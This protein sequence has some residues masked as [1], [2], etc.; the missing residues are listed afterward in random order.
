[1]IIKKQILNRLVEADIE[2]QTIKI[3]WNEKDKKE[4]LNVCNDPSIHNEIIENQYLDNDEFTE[5]YIKI[6]GKYC[7]TENCWTDLYLFD[8]IEMRLDE[9]CKKV[10]QME[11]NLNIYIPSSQ[12]YID[13][14]LIQTLVDMIDEKYKEAVIELL[15]KYEIK[16]EF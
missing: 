3:Y 9:K 4:H 7:F 8:C 5:L 15:Q 12:D 13:P 2:N 14:E 11:K 6:F 16:Y 1:M 10:K